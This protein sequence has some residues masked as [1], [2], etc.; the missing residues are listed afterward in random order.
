M[1]HVSLVPSEGL[2]Q[3]TIT[4]EWNS[5]SG[6]GGVFKDDGCRNVAIV[7]EEHKLER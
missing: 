6:G 7:Q 3:R 2:V 5:L 1:L 4:K